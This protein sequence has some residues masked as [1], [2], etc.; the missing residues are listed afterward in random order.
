MLS[1]ENNVYGIPRSDGL[2]EENHDRLPELLGKNFSFFYCLL[3]GSQGAFWHGAFR[4]NPEHK[5]PFR[6]PLYYRA[7]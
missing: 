5:F 2:T 3:K 1:G 7:S 4:G 6:R